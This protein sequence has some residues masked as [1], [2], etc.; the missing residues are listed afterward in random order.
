MCALKDII[1]YFSLSFLIVLLFPLPANANA[2]LPMI[3]IFWPLL[4]LLFIPIIFIEYGVMKRRTHALSPSPPL[5]W[6]L[7]VANLFSALIGIPLT[8]VVLVALEIGGAL[9]F[10][11]WGLD[12]NNVGSYI[13]PLT[14]PWLY[15]NTLQHQWMIV[16]ALLILLI[17]FYFISAWTEG[18]ILAWMTK[19]KGDKPLIR[20]AAWRANLYSYLFLAIFFSPWLFLEPPHFFISF[21]NTIIRFF[22]ELFFR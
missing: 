18:R 14:A 9:L 22:L 2:G 12:L 11:Q 6:P 16:A 17:P 4:C 8:W 15:P 13:W 1:K 10:S 7:V 3:I 5:F 19:N 21:S 20:K